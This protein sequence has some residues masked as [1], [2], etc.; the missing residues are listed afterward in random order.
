MSRVEQVEISANSSHRGA[1]LSLYVPLC[2]LRHRNNHL[3]P[4]MSR[5][6]GSDGEN[7]FNVA[8]LLTSK[9]PALKTWSTQNVEHFGVFTSEK[10]IS[11]TQA[12]YTQLLHFLRLG[13]SVC[14]I[15]Y[16]R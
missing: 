10:I 11:L 2:V 5:Q 6:K 16:H 7:H 3:T 15:Y 8:V 4:V 1:L 14:V 12:D 13:L 9:S